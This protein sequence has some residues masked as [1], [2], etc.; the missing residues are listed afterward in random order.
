MHQHID[1]LT[2]QDKTALFNANKYNL[3]IPITNN[4]TLLLNHK[5]HRTIK[6][7]FNLDHVTNS[8]TILTASVLTE[9][10]K[11]ERAAHRT[12]HNVE[13][14]DTIAIPMREPHHVTMHE[15]RLL[16]H[17]NIQHQ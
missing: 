11:I 8:E 12:H 14:I 16:I 6:T 1:L 4:V 10:D 13:L 3:S 17:H 5:F 9:F 7:L 15:D 2:E